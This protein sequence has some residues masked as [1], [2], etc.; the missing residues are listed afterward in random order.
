MESIF[1]N[2]SPSFDEPYLDGELKRL[3]GEIILWARTRH[4]WHDAGFETPFL[5]KSAPTLEGEVI[6]LCFDGPLHHVFY[7]GL[8]PEEEFYE[9]IDNLGYECEL[10]NY[11]CLTLT[12]K[13]ELLK[14]RFLRLYRWRWIQDLSKK[15]TLDLHGEV[16]EYFAHHKEDLKNLSWRQF[17]ELLD[18]VFKNQGF[19]TELGPGGG[20]GG[21]DIRLYQSETIPEIVTLVQAKRYKSR[22]I[23]L[24]AVAA[25]FG[26]AVEKG[27]AGG[28]LAT[29]SR[30]LPVSQ[31]FALSIDRKVG[32]PKIELADSEKIKEWCADISRHLIAYFETGMTSELPSIITSRPKTE[33]T[34]LIVV[35]KWGYTMSSNA[36]AII[37][38]DYPHEVVLKPIGQAIV[39]G[40]WQR[41]ADI[42]D[43]ESEPKWTRRAH[44]L[45]SKRLKNRPSDRVDFWG[46]EK[47][48][49][50]WDG[51]PMTFDHMD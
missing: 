2:V 35:A 37:E 27:A 15:R 12:P 3:S 42:A 26:I 20:D 33:L 1:S 22:P 40:D 16:F 17:E 36:F 6:S 34:G 18:A 10:E 44:I 11:N 41:G 47:L 32:L 29:T 13:D 21:I 5:R 25:L 4:L 49:D 48:F 46:D 8:Q 19:R 39:Q 24:D 30:F 28:I 31:K 23:T 51:Q 45:A 50:I 7:H 14:A 38:A 43:L 9:F